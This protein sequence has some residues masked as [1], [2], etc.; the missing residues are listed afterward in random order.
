LTR[1]AGTP[2][3]SSRRSGDT[4]SRRGGVRWPAHR[5][6]PAPGSPPWLARGPPPGPGAAA[7]PAGAPT[8]AR[9]RATSRATHRR[10]CAPAPG[11]RGAA[12]RARP[13][14]GIRRLEEVALRLTAGES[15]GQR[16]GA[17]PPLG[18]ELPK[19]GDGLLDDLLAHPDRAD[20]APVRVSLAILA[21]RRMAEIHDAFTYTRRGADPSRGR[22]ALHGVLV[23]GG[24]IA[25]RV[26]RAD[27]AYFPSGEPTCGSWARAD[28]PR[29][30]PQAM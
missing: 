30:L 14:S 7:A 28:G 10:R 22:S 26:T 29:A 8:A 12:G 3:R 16:P 6:G 9:A 5:G 19:L 11:A 24:P 4:T 23:R 21:A 17:G 20:Q 25:R 1:A 2:N 27:R 13:R 15:R 18:I